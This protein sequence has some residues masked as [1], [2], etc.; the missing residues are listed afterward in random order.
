MGFFDFFKNMFKK[1]NCAFCGKECGVLGRDKIKGDEYICNQC[2][3]G[4]SKYVK[5]GKFTKAEL[6]EHM[7]YM[8]RSDR[9]FNEVLGG[10]AKG[11]N[12]PAGP[13]PMSFSFYD[14]Y[15]MFVIRDKRMDNRPVELFRY[16]Q[17]ASYEPY[18]EDR[19][20]SEEGK[21]REFVEAGVKSDLLAQRI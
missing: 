21:P 16:D 7:E 9:V 20:P 8:K 2:Q 15:G 19:A 1:Q 14:E 6:L 13:D 4:V 3:Y 17:V 11:K 10:F 5:V 12:Y 18:M